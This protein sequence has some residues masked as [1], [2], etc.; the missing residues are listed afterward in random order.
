MLHRNNVAMHNFLEMKTMTNPQENM[1]TLKEFGTAGYEQMRTLGELN[2]RTLE[3]ML[4]QQMETYGLFLEAGTQQVKLS[5]EIRDRKGFLEG[6]SSLARKFSEEMAGRSRASMEL[7]N[8]L[9]KEYRDWFEQGLN[10]LTSMV[11]KSAPKAG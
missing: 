10:T 3:R 6:Q 4:E 1:E 8:E 2:L 9:Q 11:E 7:G 5:T